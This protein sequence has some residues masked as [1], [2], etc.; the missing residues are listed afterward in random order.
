M[1]LDEG[2]VSLKL[3]TTR[4]G[5]FEVPNDEILEFPEGLIG[6]EEE[7]RFVLLPTQEKSPFFW[8]QSVDDPDLAFIVSEPWGFVE[9]Y[10]FQLPQESKKKLNVKEE[11]DI[12]VLCLVVIPED[13]KKA[14]MNL[15]GPLVLNLPA[16]TG[17]QVVINE[18]FSAKHPIFKEAS[19]SA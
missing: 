1:F 13:P 19:A 10:E 6:F 2:V 18:N 3:Q 17:G 8:L 14:T 5:E 16:R 7:K 9:N 4:F 11:K 15:K 12:R